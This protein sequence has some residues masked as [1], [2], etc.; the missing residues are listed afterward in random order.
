MCACLLGRA[1]P[2]ALWI[3][4]LTEI[5]KE[6]YFWAQGTRV[7]Q[8]EFLNRWEMVQQSFKVF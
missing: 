3:V 4:S 6:D 5:S 1:L 7:I 2:C 8:L